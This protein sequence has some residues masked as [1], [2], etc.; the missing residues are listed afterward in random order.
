[1]LGAL[2]LWDDVEIR[3]RATEPDARDQGDGRARGTKAPHPF[4]MHF[5]HGGDRRRADG[6]H[7]RRPPSTARS[8]ARCHATKPLITGGGMVNTV[9]AQDAAPRIHP[10]PSADGRVPART[11]VVLA[12]EMAGASGTGQF[13]RDQAIAPP[14]D[15]AGKPRWSGRHRFMGKPHHGVAHSVLYAP[16]PLAILRCTDNRSSI[17]PERNRC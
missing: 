1:M 15:Y 2:G 3:L 13:V 8:C 11:A 9:V 5:D 4:F 7:G 16:G 12:C 6:H 17:R 14:W 10:E